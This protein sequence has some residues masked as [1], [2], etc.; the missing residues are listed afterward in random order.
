MS[1][2]SLVTAIAA[3]IIV[4]F[5]LETAVTKV[6]TSTDVTRLFRVI[7]P[8]G[9]LMAAGWLLFLSKYLIFG[10]KNN[11]LLSFVCLGATAIQLHRSILMAVSVT[12]AVVLCRLFLVSQLTVRR[13]WR[14][15]V[16]FTALIAGGAYYVIEN[17]PSAVDFVLTSL[18]EASG[19]SANS[20]H[21]YYLVVN[22]WN[23]ALS[24]TFELGLGFDWEQS[25]GLR[26]LSRVCFQFGSNF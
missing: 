7:V 23:Y 2:Y 15:A 19:L 14:V 18:G 20:G 12:L 22:S 4:A 8:G 13:R 9:L 16:L 24:D 5:Q 3:V 10:N 11:I 6:G 26:T 25:R 1:V 17:V 21:R